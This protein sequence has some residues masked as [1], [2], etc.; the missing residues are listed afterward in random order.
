M[1]LFVDNGAAKL[2]SLSTAGSDPGVISYFSHELG[3]LC[4]QIC[5]WSTTHRVFGVCGSG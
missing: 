5:S 1:F 3:K 2:V 4:L